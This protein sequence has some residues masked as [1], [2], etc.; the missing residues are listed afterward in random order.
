[1]SDHIPARL[2]ELVAELQEQARRSQDTRIAWELERTTDPELRALL[3]RA[4]KG[5]I[6]FREVL[7][8]EAYRRVHADELAEVDRV[9]RQ[10]VEEGLPDPAEA[11]VGLNAGLAQMQAEVDAARARREAE[12]EAQRVR[13]E[14]GE[15]WTYDPRERWRH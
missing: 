2:R 1:M 8:S 5:E 11:E 9:F 3:K 4:E 14:Q 7:N 15:D 13:E 12:S 10:A 6:G